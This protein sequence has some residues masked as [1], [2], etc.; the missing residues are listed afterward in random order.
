MAR[1]FYFLVRSEVDALHNALNPTVW[2]LGDGRWAMVCV[3]DANARFAAQQIEFVLS[4][5]KAFGRANE[6]VDELLE[7]ALGMTH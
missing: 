4:G 7:T 1:G 6:A 3:G 2:T 5:R